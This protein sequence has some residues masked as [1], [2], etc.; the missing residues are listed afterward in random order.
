MTSQTTLS[1]L[2]GLP[3]D[4]FVGLLGGV[5]EHSSW[6]A[7]Q[8]G[9]QRP[10]KDVDALHRAMVACVD[11]STDQAKLALIRAHPE[12]AGKAAIQGQLT[13]ESA[14]EQ[15]GAGLDQCSPQELHQLTDLNQAYREKFDFPFILAVRGYDRS[16][17]IQQIKQRLALTASQAKSESLEQIYKIARF[18]L[19]DLICDG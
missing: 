12:L 16:G 18:R 7:E 10:F 9:R 17:V 5:F 14:S 2:N 1:V 6:V 15:T 11:A 13:R 3:L 19:D 8:A 4:G